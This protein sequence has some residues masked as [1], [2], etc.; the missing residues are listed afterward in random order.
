MEGTANKGLH[1][2]IDIDENGQMVNQIL[3]KGKDYDYYDGKNQ[4][5]L[6]WNDCIR[7][8]DVSDYITMNKVQNLIRSKKYILVHL[9]PLAFNFNFNDDD[10]KRLCIRKWSKGENQQRKKKMQ[11]KN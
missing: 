9:L 7:Y 6:M 11:M 4:N 8:Q 5:I 3:Q 10:K 2:F 1:I